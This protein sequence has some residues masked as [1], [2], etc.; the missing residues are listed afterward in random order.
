MFYIMGGS[1]G[2]FR[3]QP[4]NSGQEVVWDFSVGCVAKE[5]A[6]VTRSLVRS[7]SE[8]GSNWSS[9]P[10]SAPACVRQPSGGDALRKP[11][12]AIC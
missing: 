5:T 2:P 6:T 4:D 8:L 9:I 3:G 7:M 1:R 10:S 12:S 11:L